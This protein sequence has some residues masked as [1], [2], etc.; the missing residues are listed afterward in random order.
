MKDTIRKLRDFFLLRLLLPVLYRA[1]VTQEKKLVIIALGAIGDYVLLRNWFL[2]LRNDPNYHDWDITVVG[3]RVWREI[4]EGYDD[5]IVDQWIW[6][7]KKKLKDSPRYLFQVMDSLAK[8]HYAVCLSSAY[9]REALIDCLVLST[10]A[11]QKIG[12]FGE[13]E[14]I[15]RDQKVVTDRYYTKLYDF[16]IRTMFEYRRNRLFFESFL[17]HELP[18]P[19]PSLTENTDLE[20]IVSSRSY[21]VIFPGASHENRRWDPK[22]FSKIAAYIFQRYHLPVLICGSKDERYLFSE[23]AHSTPPEICFDMTGKAL[24][25]FIGL[26]RKAEIVVTNDTAALHLSAAIKTPVVGLYNGR[27]F[28]RFSPYP[29][30]YGLRIAHLYSSKIEKRR[31]DTNYLLDK[32]RTKTDVSIQDIE[33][34]AVERAIDAVLGNP[35]R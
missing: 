19:A 35:L 22:K 28:G 6:I 27:H 31:T 32:Y 17:G 11:A 15:Q 4:A 26:L 10:C 23:I 9:T 24:P 14:N 30:E 21:A 7:D 25:E 12:Q 3:N 20:R 1:H 34:V 8:G 18:E 29:P 33:P 13:A 16:G 5:Q 2:A